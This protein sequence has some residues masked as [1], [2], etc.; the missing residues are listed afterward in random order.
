MQVDGNPIQES[1]FDVEETTQA[2]NFAAACGALTTLAGGAIAA[3]PKLREVQ[4]LVQ[5]RQ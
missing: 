1:L 3:Q 2:V 4:Q 5:S